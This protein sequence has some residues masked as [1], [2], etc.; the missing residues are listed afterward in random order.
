MAGDGQRF[1]DAGYTTPKPLIVT[2]S[3]K[4]ILQLSTES[5]PF[6]KHGG[7]S[8][9][10]A[11]RSHHLNAPDVIKQV[12]GEGAKFCMFNKLTRGNL[13]TASIACKHYASDSSGPLLVLD[14]DNI[15]DSQQFLPTVANI[16]EKDHAVIC[17]FEPEDDSEK[18]CFAQVDEQGKV[19]Q[20][21]EKKKI[22]DGYPMM[23]LFYFSSQKLFTK[24][25]E[26]II[27]N[28]EKTNN[29]FY[30][31]QAIQ[32]LIDQGVAVYGFKADYVIPLGTPEDLDRYNND[33]GDRSF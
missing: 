9:L 25:A 14:A 15:Y 16:P 31:S 8:L 23:G 4:T 10:F 32:K 18:W 3:K 5:L 12:Y 27:E 22:K 28:N 17:Y 6:I 20:L 21:S 33:Y 29:E 2:K 13:D 11:I 24:V 26:S 1:K 30:M 7:Q 19:L